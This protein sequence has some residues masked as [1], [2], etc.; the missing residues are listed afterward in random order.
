MEEIIVLS[1]LKK[2]EKMANEKK[3]ATNKAKALV[4]DAKARYIKQKTRAKSKKAAVEKDTVLNSDRFKV[5]EIYDRFEDIQECYGLEMITE[6][7]R[8]RLEALWEERE[9]IKN[10]TEDGIYKDLVTE[11]LDMACNYILEI[12]HDEIYDA[13]QLKKKFDKQVKQAEEEYKAL[14]E[15]ENETYKKLMGA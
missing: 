3:K 14:V 4:N 7:E 13:E 10:Q 11:A 2:I 1:E 6:A 5:L 15:K 12:W 9:N 8:D